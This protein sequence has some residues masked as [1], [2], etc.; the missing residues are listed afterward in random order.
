MVRNLKKKMKLN[1][2]SEIVTLVREGL[3]QSG[4]YCPCMIMQNEDTKCPCK[5]M[6]EKQ[7]CHCM[8]YVEDK[9]DEQ[10]DNQ[11]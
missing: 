1:P 8:L 10:S 6:R 3:K 11:A 2:N 9:G 7:E 4:G 5:P